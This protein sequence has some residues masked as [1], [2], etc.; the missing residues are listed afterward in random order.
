MNRILNNWDM[1]RIIRTIIGIS[2][3]GQGIASQQTSLWL[4][5]SLF[6]AMAVLNVGCFGSSNCGVQNNKSVVKTEN[7][8]EVTYEEIR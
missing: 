7:I 3:I 2:I 1:V 5:G 4:M 8:D 6:T